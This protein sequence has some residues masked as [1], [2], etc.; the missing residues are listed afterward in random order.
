M[1]KKLTP[2]LLLE[3][4]FYLDQIVISHKRKVYDVV[5]L[6]GDLGGVTEVLMLVM[7]FLLFPISE[8]SYNIMSTKRLFLARTKESNLFVQGDKTCKKGKFLGNQNM[9]KGIRDKLKKEID[10]H[11]Y[12]RMNYKDK[13]CYYLYNQLGWLFFCNKCWKNQDKITKLID[14]AQDR[15]DQELNIVKI[16]QTLRNMKVVLKSSLMG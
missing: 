14:E 5:A 3:H 12:V 4:N 6:L 11:R 7:G 10:K 13:I 1:Y 16:I 15:L 2:N 9:P 8:S